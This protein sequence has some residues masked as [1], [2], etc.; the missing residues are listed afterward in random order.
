MNQK[1]EDYRTLAVFVAVADA[2]SFA[3]AGRFLKL[4]TSVISHHI[5]RLEEKLGVSLFVRSTRSM[6]L[7]PEGLKM[8]ESARQMVASG[9]QAM[10]ALADISEKP[11]GELRITMPVFKTDTIYYH[12]IW[13]FVKQNPR[14]AVK[15]H[16]SD[17]QL[18]LVKEGF[19]LALRF[20]KMS[21]SSLKSR[22]IGEFQRVLVATPDYLKKNPPIRT[23]DDLRENQFVSVAM[24]SHGFTL[25]KDDDVVKFIPEKSPIKVNTVTAAKSAVLA[26]L[27]IQRLPEFEIRQELV[28]G[29]LVRVLPDWTPS[30]LGVYVVWPD[31][32]RQ[33]KLTR[34]FID[35]L[36]SARQP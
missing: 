28:N 24:L 3:Q 5:G 32:N 23:L 31:V 20:G 35:Y 14:V 19:D 25:L 30:A 12:H 2:G 26:G 8:L 4:S 22:K 18:D 34:C 16:A 10:D 29:S 36:V 6:C 15:L 27:G 11:V 21:N 7:T 13:S 33:K 9:Q 1:L 17:T